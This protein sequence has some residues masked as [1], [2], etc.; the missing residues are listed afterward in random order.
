MLDR[1]PEEEFSAQDD[2]QD[3]ETYL[4][5]Q[6]IRQ[7]I[8]QRLEQHGIEESTEGDVNVSNA[9]KFTRTVEA[10]PAAS[11]VW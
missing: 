2:D 5:F 11:S 9:E 8:L 10:S 3:T 7:K 6:L 1:Y 4:P